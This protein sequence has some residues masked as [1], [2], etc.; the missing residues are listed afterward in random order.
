MNLDPLLLVLEELEMVVI[1]EMVVAG[2]GNLIL[3]APH[4]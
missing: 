4:L 2:K 1:L 3:I